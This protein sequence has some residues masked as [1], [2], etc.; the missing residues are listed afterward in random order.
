MNGSP[1]CSIRR[2]AIPFDTA[3]P[4]ASSSISRDYLSW[5]ALVWLQR[6]LIL[7][8]KFLR[9]TKISD[10]YRRPEAHHFK[11]GLGDIPMSAK[12]MKAGAVDVLSKPIQNS[13]LA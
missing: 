10:T 9:A 7:A 1:I 4:D 11:P 8:K 12:R 2:V 3:A 5:V 6:T 13:G